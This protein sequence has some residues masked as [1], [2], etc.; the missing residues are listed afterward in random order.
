MLGGLPWGV[1]GA[2]HKLCLDM[3]IRQP[4]LIDHNVHFCLG[5]VVHIDHDGVD[6][7][8]LF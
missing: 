4:C 2:V 5:L 8:G 1:V 3:H 6:I 7:V